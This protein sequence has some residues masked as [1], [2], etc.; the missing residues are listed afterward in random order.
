MSQHRL[1]VPFFAIRAAELSHRDYAI[2]EELG[3]FAQ[4][5]K[6]VFQTLEHLDPLL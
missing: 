5:S 1:D 4:V 3:M 6:D 2:L